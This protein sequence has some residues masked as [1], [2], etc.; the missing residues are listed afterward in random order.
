MSEKFSITKR[1]MDSF[2]NLPSP[3]SHNEYE[4]YYLINGTRKIFLDDSIYILNRG[5]LVFIPMN[6]LHRVTYGNDKPH[7]RIN[8]R[9]NDDYVPDIK[10]NQQLKISFKK[11]FIQSPVIHISGTS[12]DYIESLFNRILAEYE[13]ADDFSDINIKN[14]LQEL[15]IFLIRYNLYK[16]NEYAPNI[17]MNDSIMQ[18]AAR[19]I[20]TNY[21]KNITLE[22][23]A[24]H[25][26]IS[27]TYFSKKFKTAT[28]F[29]YREYLINIRIQ[30]ACK[31]LLES[32]MSI[33]QIALECGFNDSN[34]F[35]DVFRRTKGIAPF[36]YRKNNN[37]L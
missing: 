6:T 23:V 28:G 19:F 26:N 3:H 21:K 17:D 2:Y 33:T 32:N 15:V 11:T 8:L 25:V 9:F 14:C 18:E 27:P 7:E 16:N 5:D 4:I 13:Q 30:E 24:E 29:G 12:R 36:K 1:K 10:K 22:T 37:Y 31:L 20:R 35:G 34:Y